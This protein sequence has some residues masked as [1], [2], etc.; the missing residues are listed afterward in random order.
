LFPEL[1]QLAGRLDSGQTLGTGC[2]QLFPLLCS[3]LSAAASGLASQRE[4][5]G[6]DWRD[7][8]RFEFKRRRLQVLEEYSKIRNFQNASKE[9]HVLIIPR[10]LVRVQ[11]PAPLSNLLDFQERIRPTCQQRTIT[12][13]VFPSSRYDS[14]TFSAWAFAAIIAIHAVESHFRQAVQA[15][16]SSPD[17]RFLF[18]INVQV[19]AVLA[20]P[21]LPAS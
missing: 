4:L 19:S 12:T 14:A 8:E 2:L 18:A 20:R 16:C 10:S 5:F 6:A 15:E 9:P 13:C 3:S 21:V 1:K 17:L 11:P 7:S